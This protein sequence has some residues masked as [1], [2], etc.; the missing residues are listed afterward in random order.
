M[1]F[2]EAMETVPALSNDDLARMANNPGGVTVRHGKASLICTESRWV[3]TGPSGRHSIS[4]CSDLERVN[5][6]WRI[7]ASHD[8]NQEDSA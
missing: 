3:M 4:A 6:H 2:F 5:A 8:L 1:T 7:F